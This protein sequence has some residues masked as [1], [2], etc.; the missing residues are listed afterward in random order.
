M[1]VY[2]RMSGNRLVMARAPDRP[3][4]ILIAAAMCVGLSSGAVGQIGP[5]FYDRATDAIRQMF[6]DPV[7]C[8]PGEH[9]EH[10][11][12][13]WSKC[14]AVG[15]ERVSRLFDYSPG[16]VKIVSDY[17]NRV[18][19]IGEMIEERTL[20]RDEALRKISDERDKFMKM[21]SPILEDRVYREAA[22]MK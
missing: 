8:A 2:V 15:A 5:T 22:E 3:K 11:W 12:V 7:S 13:E 21:L 9:I 16:V 4:A 10:K 18:K 19:V 1:D 6:D 20:K 17:Q 14:L